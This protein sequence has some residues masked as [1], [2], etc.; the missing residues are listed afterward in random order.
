M[1]IV[2]HYRKVVVEKALARRHQFELGIA[3]HLAI[4][5]GDQFSFNEPFPVLF[6]M[7]S[8]RSY[9]AWRGLYPPSRSPAP[10]FKWIILDENPGTFLKCALETSVVAMKGNDAMRR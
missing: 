3:R 7:T 5:R 10:C 1:G 4:L 2:E 8:V 6:S 9:A